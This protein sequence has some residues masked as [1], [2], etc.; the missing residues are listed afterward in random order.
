MPPQTV[1]DVL[2]SI[3]KP[4]GTPLPKPEYRKKI[5]SLT[6]YQREV[7]LAWHN[8]SQ[9]MTNEGWQLQEGLREAGYEL[10]G[11]GY[12]KG[13]T[14]VP[15]VL[16][17]TNPD[18][19]IIQDKREWDST[20][21]A[22]FDKTA[23]WVSSYVLAERSDIFKLTILKDAHQQQDYHRE[24][25]EEI[26]CHAWIT[27][28]HPA[29]IAQ[30][31][32]YVRQEH[33]VRTYH[34]LDRDFVP[35]YETYPREGCLLSGALGSYYPLRTRL[36]RR[37][38]KIRAEYLK[39]PGYHAKGSA[40]NEYLHTLSRYKVA[41]CTASRLGYVLRK[42]IEATA[43]GCRVITDLP[44]DEPLPFIDDNLIR[45]HP[46]EEMSNIKNL[47]RSATTTYDEDTQRG[48]A[49]LAKKHYDYRVLGAQLRNNIETLRRSY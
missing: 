47:V 31:A 7:F 40:T 36:A 38:E 15:V 23:S 22:C 6:P 45:I 24:A 28:Y 16:R 19:L 10:W 46:L 43:C 29:I 1:Q 13:D 44:L 4:E 14:R 32:P 2:N 21:R 8:F 17:E 5:T 26:G 35:A 34:S 3:E 11:K 42:I 20:N 49:E 39:H 48:Y 12:E 9:H 37:A 33:L 41:I 30:L 18:T 25:A 27:Y